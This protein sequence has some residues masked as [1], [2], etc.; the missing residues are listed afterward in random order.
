MVR[1]F[2]VVCAL[3]IAGSVSAQ[4]FKYYKNKGCKQFDL[5]GYDSEAKEGDKT[6]NINKFK[7]RFGGIITEQPIFSS[8]NKYPFLRKVLRNVRFAKRLYKKE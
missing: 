3:L 8:N 1:H 6:Y 4:E 7:E 5:G 2:S